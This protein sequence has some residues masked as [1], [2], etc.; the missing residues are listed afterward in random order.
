MRR[1]HRYDCGT[2]RPAGHSARAASQG[3]W[4]KQ[5]WTFAINIK[6]TKSLNGFGIWKQKPDLN[7]RAGPYLQTKLNWMFRPQ[8]WQRNQSHKSKF[9]FCVSDPL[10]MLIILCPFTVSNVLETLK[11]FVKRIIL[12]NRTHLNKLAGNITKKQGWIGLW[13]NSCS[14]CSCVGIQRPWGFS[15]VS[16][17]L[18][19]QSLV[20]SPSPV[21][22]IPI[23]S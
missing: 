12:P 7:V 8:L 5:I 13:L 4:V 18:P 14:L 22:W 6:V 23:N 9:A 16:I 10:V 11:W 15:Y 20:S 19:M 2:G 17:T 21:S 1:K 3:H